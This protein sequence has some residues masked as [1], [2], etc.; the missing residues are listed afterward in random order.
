MRQERWLE[1]FE[2]RA[3]K[4]DQTRQFRPNGWPRANGSSVVRTYYG[5][6]AVIR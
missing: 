4:G 2:A 3:I 5:G 6:F 1:T